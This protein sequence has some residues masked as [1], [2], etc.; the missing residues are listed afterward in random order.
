MAEVITVLGKEPT[1]RLGEAVYSATAVKTLT[2]DL[3]PD[4][5]LLGLFYRSRMGNV[6]FGFR[7][8]IVE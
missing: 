8:E 4:V 2:L 6:A 1:L 7:L 3:P 5:Y